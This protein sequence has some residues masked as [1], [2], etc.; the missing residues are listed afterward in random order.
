LA[1]IRR[2]QARA[3]AKEPVLYSVSG[4]RLWAWPLLT[5][6]VNF[7]MRS[8][9]RGRQRTRAEWA[10]LLTSAGFVDIESYPTTGEFTLIS[11]T[12]MKR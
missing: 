2:L 3:S 7:V 5:A 9:T 10:N 11:A 8:H 6:L 4:A 1:A 12:A